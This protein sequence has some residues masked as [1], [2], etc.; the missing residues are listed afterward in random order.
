MK[1]TIKTRIGLFTMAFSLFLTTGCSDFLEESD[2]TNITAE[3]YFETAEHA[4]SA[5]ISNIF[6]FKIG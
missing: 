6:Q 1:N 3:S 4:E 2:P 5:V